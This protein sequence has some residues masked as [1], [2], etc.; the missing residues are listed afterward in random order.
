MTGTVD[1]FYLAKHD[2]ISTPFVKVK[3]IARGKLTKKVELKVQAASQAV[4][5]AIEKQGGKFTKTPTP[6]KP[7]AKKD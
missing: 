1:N 4:V 3:V 5:A 7:K 2:Y 6:L